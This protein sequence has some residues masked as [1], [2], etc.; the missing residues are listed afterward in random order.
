MSFH[1]WFVLSFL[2]HIQRLNVSS[3]AKV[4]YRIVGSPIDKLSLGIGDSND[5]M[6]V[7]KLGLRDNLSI[8]T[9]IVL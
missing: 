8:F 4:L 2:L 9:H 7:P 6:Q 5:S 1:L 3:K